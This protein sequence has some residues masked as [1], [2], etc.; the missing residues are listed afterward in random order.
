MPRCIRCVTVAALAAAAL[1]FLIQIPVGITH[2]SQAR[3]IAVRFSTVITMKGA[4]VKDGVI[5][6]EGDRI[7]SVGSGNRAVPAGA[8]VI[9]MRPLVAIPGLIDAH[10]HMTYVWD[11]AS[12]T[13]PLNQPPRD[14]AQ[15]V[16]LAEANARR[17]LETGVTTVRDLAGRGTDYA[18]RDAINTGRMTGPRMFVAG[19]GISGGRSSARC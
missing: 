15:T 2:A 3:L 4:P 5:V 16:L 12:G 6:I 9:D 10:T 17:T 7:R 14:A 8:E 19:S 11:P 1:V 18:M 13:R